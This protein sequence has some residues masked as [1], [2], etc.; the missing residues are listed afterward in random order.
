MSAL[1]IV[2]L[3]PFLQGCI[4]QFG[5]R[6][7][8]FVEALIVVVFALPWTIF[9]FRDEPAQWD[10]EAYGLDDQ[11]TPSCRSAPAW[12]SMASRACR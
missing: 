11:A 2:V 6:N 4:S 10:A 7:A 8:Y 12:T 9:V 5:W 3:S 1:A